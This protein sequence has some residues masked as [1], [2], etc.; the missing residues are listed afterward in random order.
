VPRW[1]AI[2]LLLSASPLAAQERSAES[3]H[4]ARTSTSRSVGAP[5]RGRLTDG[6]ELRA[7][8]H[9]SVAPAGHP[10]GTEE[11]VRMIERAAARVQTE[12]PGPRLLVGALSR[13]RGGRVPPHSSHQSGRDADLGFYVTDENGAPVYADRFVELDTISQCGRDRDRV[14]CLDGARTFLLIVALLADETARVQWILLA[15]DIQQRI[16]AAGRRLSMSDEI[17]RAVELATD[18]RDGS[19]GHRNHLH[20]RIHCPP[21]DVPGCADGAYR[22]AHRR[23]GR[24][25]RRRR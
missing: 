25:P 10:Y 11:L 4:G 2:A 13:Q 5:N 16:L 21:D 18:P 8:E 19:E 24:P 22:P 12:S 17:L 14:Y 15:P 1:I 6:V 9:L 23:R 20:V 3:G 7:T